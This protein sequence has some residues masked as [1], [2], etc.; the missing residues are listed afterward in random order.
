MLAK[1]KNI[2]TRIKKK[3]DK[4]RE[5]PINMN[6]SVKKIDDM[7]EGFLDFHKIKKGS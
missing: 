1:I 2:Q 3:K 7:V 4:K 6:N 5:Y